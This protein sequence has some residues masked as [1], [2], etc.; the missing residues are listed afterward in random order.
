MDGE[1]FLNAM[2]VVLQD[3]AGDQFMED[4]KTGKADQ[5]AVVK[6]VLDDKVEGWEEHTDKPVIGP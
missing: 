2:P 4:I 3:T 5:E 6:T 1:E